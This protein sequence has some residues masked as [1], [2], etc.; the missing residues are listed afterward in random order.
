[1]PSLIRPEWRSQLEQQ[2]DKLRRS[3]ENLSEREQRLLIVLGVVAI[4]M[5]VVLPLSLAYRSMSEITEENDE[6]RSI[7][8]TMERRKLVFEEKARR[9]RVLER[10][11]RRDPPSLSTFVAERAKRYGVELREFSDQPAKEMEGFTRRSV[12]ARLPDGLGLAT[13]IQLMAAIGNSEYP[14]AIEAIRI[15]HFQPG[16]SYN[17]VEIDVVAYERKRGSRS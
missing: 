10:K 1:M 5:L 16:D 12:R 4:A 15:E 6:I 3:F 7:L 14:I 17:N 13:I 11:Y 9:Q 8:A 2:R